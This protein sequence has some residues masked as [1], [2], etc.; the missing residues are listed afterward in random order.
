MVEAQR[1]APAAASPGGRPLVVR[2]CN[3]VGEVVL[4]LPSLRR[5]ESAGYR[6]HLVGKGWAPALL[7][8]TGWPVT[9]H[10][11]GLRAG[12]SR[13]RQIRRDLQGD[14]ALPVPALLFTKSL[15]SALEARM[16]GLSAAGY[17]Y[18]GRSWLLARALRMPPFHSAY[19]SYW[20]LVGAFL[21]SQAP[22]P[23]RIDMTP[24]AAQRE[25]AQALL[26]G[27]GLEAGHYVLL[28]P[29]SGADDRENRKAWPG[30]PALIRLLREA[31]IPTL[32]CPGPGEEAAA[33]DLCA[34]HS[35]ARV[36]LGTYGALLES[37]RAV[38][39][40]DTG[41]GHLAAAVGARLISL[42]GPHSVAAWAPL[43]T[44]VTL[45]HD[46]K[47][48]PAAMAVAEMLLSG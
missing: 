22:Y 3:W 44:R 40:N 24:S 20:D 27:L 21:G 17:A 32:V 39:A 13:L 8:G 11:R 9:P 28:C 25:R 7:E 47:G 2:L 30:Y 12:A 29:F 41:P 46:P 37:A 1:S 5:L 35:L 14:T 18:D 4:S 43:G 48:W 23:T 34:T 26:A 36:D 38:V 45:L 6:L 31:G 42:Y 33:A 15:S 10:P 16:A 19:R